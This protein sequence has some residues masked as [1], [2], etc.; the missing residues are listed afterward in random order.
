MR[1]KLGI[2][3]VL[4][5]AAIAVPGS[6][7]G[8]EVPLATDQQVYAYLASI[9]VD[10]TGVVIQRGARNYAGPNCPGPGWN[11][12]TA[13]KVVQIAE[14]NGENEFQ[15]ELPP[16]EGGNTESSVVVRCMVVARN[17]QTH[18]RCVERAEDVPAVVLVCKLDLAGEN[19]HAYVDQTAI[20]DEGATQSATVE[21]DVMMDAER[22]NHLVL[23]QTI[24]QATSEV[25]GS[26]SVLSGIQSQDGQLLTDIDQDAGNNN[27]AHFVQ[28]LDQRGN[29]SGTDVTQAQ[30][31]QHEG[32]VTQTA[33]V[34]GS[35][36]NHFEAHQTE[37]QVLS[38]DGTQSQFGPQ[39]CCA[40]QI[41]NEQNSSLHIH[42]DS[43]Q[44]ANQP[45]A[46]Q[47]SSTTGTYNTAASGP[48][49]TSP[50]DTGPSKFMILHHL[51][52]NVDRITAQESGPGAHF[53]NTECHSQ[54]EEYTED[55]GC[56]STAEDGEL[57]LL[58][59]SVPAS[60]WP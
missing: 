8:T 21:A 60:E 56:F 28:E 16:P 15:C 37:R 50:F 27:D 57:D 34:E 43:F 25:G 54:P 23:H 51:A 45:T 5:V 55:A 20:Q 9:G 53:V 38:G 6:G 49:A 32:R 42:Q 31:G 18:A 10:P 36:G 19:V 2:L 39:F 14:E 30:T 58:E 40:S 4:A 29:A 1:F 47:D 33:P 46:D 24:K 35:G 26:L 13:T 52:N 59:H 48:T 17:G 11:C 12:T 41:G 44:R 22:D 7:A 3:A